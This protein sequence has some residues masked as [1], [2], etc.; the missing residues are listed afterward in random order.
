MEFVQLVNRTK[1]DLLVTYDGRCYTL[2][3][4][5]NT[6][7]SFLIG[8]AKRQCRVMGTEDPMNPLDF[9]TLVGVPGVD[10]CSPKEQSKKVEA[11]DRSLVVDPK[12]RA[13]KVLKTSKGFS[14]ALVSGDDLPADAG[15]AAERT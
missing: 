8:P 1:G 11:L 15:F 10:D 14:R 12:R 7:P 13:A 6:V 3:P 5:T 9:D 4:G 2:A